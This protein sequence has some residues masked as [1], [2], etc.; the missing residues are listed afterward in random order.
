MSTA[1]VA[2]RHKVP[3]FTFTLEPPEKMERVHR[4]LL[5]GGIYAPCIEYPGGPTARFFR[6]T[7]CAKHSPEQVRQLG[8]ALSRAL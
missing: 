2:S 4:T 6:L 3:I 7:A 5:A 1:A 8:D